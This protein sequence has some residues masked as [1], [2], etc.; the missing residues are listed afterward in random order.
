VNDAVATLFV[1]V[2]LV[3]SLPGIAV[4]GAGPSAPAE[5]TPLESSLGAVAGADGTNETVRHQNPEEYDGEA[6]DEELE[7]WL[8]DRLSSQL[9]D[10]SVALSEGEYELARD[11]MGDEYDERLEQYAEVSGETDATDDD[12]DEENNTE[13]AY[14]SAAE[15]QERLTDLVEEYE[16]TQAAYEEALD[17]G[18]DQRAHDL[19]R[20]LEE[21][22]YEIDERSDGLVTSYE[23][24]GN[25]TGT[26][27][28][29]SA[30][31]VE[32]TRS[33]VD[34]EQASVRDQQFVE[35]ELVLETVGESISFGDPLVARG[36]VQA[37]DGS[38]V[39]PNDVQLLVDGEPVE[40]G[41]AETDEWWADDGENQFEFE[42]RPTVQELDT[43]SL[44]V[45]YL[46]T[47]ES[48][49]TRS[50]TEL[51]V[52]IEQDEPTISNVETTESVAYG[53]ELR[54]DGEI[55]VD[56]VPV[57]GVPLAVSIGSEHLGTL[58]ATDGSFG[59]T[60]EL[61]ANISD[62][63]GAVEVSLPFEEQALASTSAES[64]IQIGETETELD[65]EA[66]AIGENEIAIDGQF[67]SADGEGL[68]G[69][70]IELRV[71]GTAVETVA[72]GPD[73]EFNESLAFPETTADEVTVAATYEGAGTNLAAAESESTVAVPGGGSSALD[74]VPPSALAVLGALAVV[75]VLTAIGWWRRRGAGDSSTTTVPEVTAAE[76]D[77]EVA[78]RASREI[79][80]TL[81]SRARQQLANGRPDAAIRSC[82]AAVRHAL[83]AGGD[84]TGGLTHW[85]FYRAYAAAET[86]DQ[87][88]E[89]TEA[90]ERA[91]FTPEPVQGSTA[92]RALARTRELCEFDSEADRQQRSEAPRPGDD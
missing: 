5:S 44:T 7:S 28:S 19:A 53:D 9:E 80:E 33:E 70:P 32:Q 45:E 81:L 48:T 85:E 37:D 26:D 58:N 69:E 41:A 63:E 83:A 27:F 4:A 11:T 16:E 54:I 38:T 30:E 10:S 36:E 43:E 17:D 21:L 67:G 39:D 20:D 3:G 46:P 56:G 60:G 57:D 90:Y 22:Y 74:T 50:E 73:G 62:G 86:N 76:P 23:T 59:G 51:D 66:T 89:L 24:I 2:L 42:Y 77:P 15:D 71:D 47:N 75:L 6:D 13:E 52:Q 55:D 29:E 35:T 72:T 84:D 1:A 25:E 82:Y 88:R 78:A 91:A 79:A 8:S 92:E 14:R 34:S 18:D 49:L 65:A 87:L 68:E 40:A 64:P 61:P 31:S 12:D